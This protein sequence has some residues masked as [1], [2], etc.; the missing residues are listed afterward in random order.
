VIL[1]KDI[2]FLSSLQHYQVGK[3]FFLLL[4]LLLL[5]LVLLSSYSFH[6]SFSSSCASFYFSIFS[7]F[8]KNVASYFPFM[9]CDDDLKV[10]KSQL[11]HSNFGT[12]IDHIKIFNTL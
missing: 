7:Y 12:K 2:P 8:L 5:L 9:Q 1:H 11:F 3:K 4:L 6:S 10:V